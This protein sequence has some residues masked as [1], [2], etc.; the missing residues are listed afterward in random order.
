MKD[1][2]HDLV[3]RIKANGGTIRDAIDAL[4]DYM[5]DKDSPVTRTW[6]ET[7]ILKIW[8]DG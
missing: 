3:L 5:H 7:F 6:C 4:M 2:K 8:K 1:E